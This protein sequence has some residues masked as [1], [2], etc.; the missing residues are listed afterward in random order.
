MYVT[1]Y[2]PPRK[3]ESMG[4]A[5]CR[6]WGKFI[7][8]SILV[9]G[10]ALAQPTY[11]AEPN[12][13]TDEEIADG[14]IMLFDGQSLFGWKAANMADWKAEGGYLV[15]TTG[16]QGL[17][18]T[19]SQFSNYVLKVDFRCA[20]GGN[21]G[22][23]LRT[24]PVSSDPAIDAYEVNIADA[25]MN[26]YPN[27]SI[28][29]RGKGTPGN[30]NGEWQTY[31]ITADGDRIVVKLDGR[32]TLD[33]KD[34]KPLGRGHIGLQFNQGKAEFRNIKLK[35]LGQKSIF[36]SK[37]LSGWKQPAGTQSVCTV[38]PDGTLSVKNGK[39]DLETDGQY[40]DFVL[41][42]EAR[43]AKGSNSGVFFRCIPGEMM[44]GYECQI[45]NGFKENDRAKPEDCGTGGFYRF[46]DAR[47]VIPDDGKWFAMTILAGGNHMA[48][49]INGYQVTD[50]TDQRAANDNP[51]NGQRLKAGTIQL[52]GHDASTDV[53]LRKVQIA[54]LPPR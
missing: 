19:T 52:Q 35:P 51:R 10:C 7:L 54:E 39:G 47:K 21:S 25:G 28:A 49:W 1:K 30:V 32:Q 50:W 6:F 44:N 2:K 41:Q 37:D 23:F 3:G 31:E 14:W 12:K 11:A 36:N 13:L 15:G 46:Q 16:D 17:I 33:Y 43:N 4:V 45:Q 42:L 48:S 22:V 40:A 26:D 8:G 20:K 18:H 34:P 5:T 29:K 53:S 24:L 38:A 9:L 27:G